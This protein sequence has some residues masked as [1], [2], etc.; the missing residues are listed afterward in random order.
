MFLNSLIILRS[1][2]LF[3]ITHPSTMILRSSSLH[4]HHIH[5]LSS[6]FFILPYVQYACISCITHSSRC[7]LSSLIFVITLF[8]SMSLLFFIISFRSSRYSIDNSRFS[9]SHPI[10]Y[11]IYCLKYTIYKIIDYYTRYFS[12][13]IQNR[14][15]SAKSHR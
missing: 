7:S 4:Y 8:S 6:R 5:L 10:F 12:E 14:P 1:S 13:I 2:S 3:L 11:M 15:I 9:C